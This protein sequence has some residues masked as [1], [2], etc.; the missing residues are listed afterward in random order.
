VEP[1]PRRLGAALRAFGPGEYAFARDDDTLIPRS[2]L[3][4]TPCKINTVAELPASREGIA[5]RR[6]FMWSC[7][8]GMRGAA[9]V[10]IG[11]YVLSRH[12]AGK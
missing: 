4:V 3:P 6:G 5:G 11:I 7:D 12:L 9:P 2:T 10:E 8:C 1:A